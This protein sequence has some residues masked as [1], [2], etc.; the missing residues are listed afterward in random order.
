MHR[1]VR[2]PALLNY[3]LGASRPQVI[4]RGAHPEPAC[5]DCTYYVGAFIIVTDS[6][7]GVPGI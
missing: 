3:G 5:L 6:I 2:K 7:A 4:C 1:D